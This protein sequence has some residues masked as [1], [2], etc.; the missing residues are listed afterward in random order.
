MPSGLTPATKV[1]GVSGLT[2]ATKKNSTEKVT[3]VKA[4]QAEKAEG[5][6]SNGK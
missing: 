5:K 6:I 1:E 2:P 4:N 3:L